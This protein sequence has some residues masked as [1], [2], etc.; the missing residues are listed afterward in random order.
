MSWKYFSEDELACKC[1]K[2]ETEMDDEFMDN[3]VE[4]RER[5]DFPFIVTSAYRCFDHNEAI[6]GH[7]GSRHLTGEALDILCFGKEAQ[8]LLDLAKEHGMNGIGV[9]QK[10]AF[11][12][13]F[14]HLDGRTKPAVW[15][16]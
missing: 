9:S 8:T 12:N 5:A 7:P 4:L 2:C 1:G 15:S 6:G 16:Y 14:I 13:R 3:M 10:G 11:G